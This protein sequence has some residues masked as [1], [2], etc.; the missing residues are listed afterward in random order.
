MGQILDLRDQSTC[1]NL[2]NFIKKPSSELKELCTSA[3]QNQIQTLINAEGENVP[4]IQTL[5]TE[6]A[7]V[8]CYDISIL[9]ID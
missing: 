9:F 8:C 1:P 5:K 7:K 3:I 2:K 4:L 6:L